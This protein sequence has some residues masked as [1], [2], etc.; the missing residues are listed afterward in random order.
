M[1][2]RTITHG[3]TYPVRSYGRN[4]GVDVPVDGTWTAAMRVSTEKIS[5]PIFVDVPLT[6]VNGAFVAAID[7]S[8]PPWKPGVYYYDIR[9]TPP[10]TPPKWSEGVKL[11]LKPKN[12]PATP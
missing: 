10:G 5:G 9:I 1:I 3:A 4:A 7:T 8:L 6:L 11:T 2:T 12:S